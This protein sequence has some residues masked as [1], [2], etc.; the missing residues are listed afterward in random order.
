MAAS[1]AS[2]QRRLRDYLEHRDRVSAAWREADVYAGYTLRVTPEEL[3][4]LGAQ[5]DA[6]IR[7]L[8]AA[9]REDAP[10]G[11]ELVTVGL[12]AFPRQEPRWSR[13]AP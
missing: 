8:I 11:A 10:A 1:V 9:L 4:R 3:Q 12:S 13:P 5:L 7:P 6:L 2:D